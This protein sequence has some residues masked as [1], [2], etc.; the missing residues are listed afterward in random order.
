VEECFHGAHVWMLAL[1][2]GH[3]QMRIWEYS[4]R[5]QKRRH[6]QKNSCSSVFVYG[7]P[8]VNSSGT[9]LGSPVQKSLLR[10]P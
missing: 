9:R 2:W 5:L 6:P 10:K 8:R 7:I 4:H 3:H 1:D